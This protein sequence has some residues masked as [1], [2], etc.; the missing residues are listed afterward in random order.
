[1]IA[2]LVS[3]LLPE[4]ALYLRAF[5]FFRMFFEKDM[6]GWLRVVVGL[7]QIIGLFIN[8][9]RKN[10]TPWIR[11]FSTSVGFMVFGGINCCFASSG[12]VST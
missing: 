6:L 2:W 5:T 4:R 9:A 11:V 8:G 3:L 12:V 7:L 1:M 10:V